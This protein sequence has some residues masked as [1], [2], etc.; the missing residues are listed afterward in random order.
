MTNLVS[1]TVAVGS[2]P[3]V[4]YFLHI[5]YCLTLNDI[6]GHRRILSTY[7]CSFSCPK[8][9]PDCLFCDILDRSV[10]AKLLGNVGHKI[11]F[12]S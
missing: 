1:S 3:K 10:I 12:K 11:F 6:V 8:P 5:V 9:V 7:T 2:F 4:E